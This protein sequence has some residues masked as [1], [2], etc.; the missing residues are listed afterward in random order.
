MQIDTN[1]R[2]ALKLGACAL[3]MFGFGYALVPM[4]NVVCRVT[5]LNGRTGDISPAQAAAIA[6]D[7]SR[8]LT[9]E[10]DTN[11]NGALPWAFQP[12]QRSVQVHP[13]E[14]STVLFVAENTSDHTVVG[15]AVPNVAPAKA[16][17]FFNKTECFCF[18][19]QTL[20]PKERREMPV[21]FIVDPKVPPEVNTLTLSYTF[22]EVPDRL[23]KGAPAENKIKQSS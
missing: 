14:L 23:R 10:F 20:A 4:Y 3:A 12:L 16:S 9:V 19:Q 13:G 1:S 17:P 22:F 5:G 8:T 18:S 2:T 11:V 15:Q 6:P 7:P 21:R